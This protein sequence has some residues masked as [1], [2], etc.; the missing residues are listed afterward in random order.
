MCKRLP[1]SCSRGHHL[2]CSQPAASLVRPCRPAMAA[3]PAS[4]APSAHVVNGFC[5]RGPAD[6]HAVPP[7]K[8][9]ACCTM[10]CYLLLPHMA[11]THACTAD[12]SC[13]SIQTAMK[14]ALPC[15]QRRRCHVAALKRV[16]RVEGLSSAASSRA[17]HCP[18][19]IHPALA[20]S[21]W[22][23]LRGSGGGQEGRG[24]GSQRGM[25]PVAQLL[26]HCRC[27]T[28]HWVHAGV[29]PYTQARPSHSICLTATSLLL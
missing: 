5:C 29:L 19:G 3:P 26:N 28:L 15:M 27:T 7:S 21:N 17:S 24:E 20:A 18:S 4:T 1:N 9:H 12:P 2:P 23:R 16:H 25:S 11:C 10:R 14:R 22:D 8:Q 6:T 13:G